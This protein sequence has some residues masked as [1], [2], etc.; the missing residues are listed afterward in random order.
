LLKRLKTDDY[1]MLSYSFVEEMVLQ[2]P[3]TK[4][5]F[6]KKLKIAFVGSRGI[7]AKYGG[8]ETF[9]EEISQ[10]LVKLGFNVFVTCQTR[11]FGE[12]I[13]KGV[14]RVHIPSFQGKTFT[15]PLMNDILATLYLLRKHPD[16]DIIYYVTP[17]SS[18]AAMLPKMLGKKIIVNTDGIEWLRPLVRMKFYPRYLKLVFI[19]TYILLRL[20][21]ILAV[22]LSDVVI[23][24]A[25][26]IKSHLMRNYKTDKA[27][28]ISYGTRELF[29]RPVTPG[30]EHKILKKF[31]L[32][33]R[34]YYLTVGRIVPENGIHEEIIGFR[35]S[36]SRKKLVIVGN[37]NYK[38]SYT[39]YLV[40][41]RNS[42]P[43]I[44]F[45]DAIY[46]KLK[47]GVIRKN[48][49][50]YI[51]PYKVGG[52]N[53]SLI[54][55]LQFGSIVIA[56]NLPFHREIL[57]D[58][59]FYFRDENELAMRIREVEKFESNLNEIR[60]ALTNRICKEYSWETIV[61][62]YCRT[63]VRLLSQQVKLV[64]N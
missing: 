59:G 44:I 39:K 43:N 57:G 17:H 6:H 35:K 24:D 36:G 42:D 38:D 41:L 34:T 61:A 25:R 62:K 46:D 27:I 29:K 10:R 8:A 51:H 52:T 1:Q 45:K 3:Y 31:G 33:P 15:I 13:Y 14:I 28:F 64:D 5:M 12:D 56:R 4:F 54:E 60:K 26:S 58:Y 19:A 55:Q 30:E 7:P 2:K 47:L 20:T 22:R 40:K 23:A 37:F 18:P 32:E 48:C 16:I 50:A 11:Q 21:E 9:V 63:F 49:F 53:P